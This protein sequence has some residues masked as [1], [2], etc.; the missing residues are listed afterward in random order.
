MHSELAAEVRIMQQHQENQTRLLVQTITNLESVGQAAGQMDLRLQGELQHLQQ[1][2]ARH[3]DTLRQLQQL[4]TET[5]KKTAL[6]EQLL[7]LL[8]HEHYPINE[9]L[10]EFISGFRKEFKVSDRLE[11]RIARN[12]LMFL[13]SL[14]HLGQYHKA[15]HHYLSAGLNAYKLVNTLVS[16]R[17]GEWKQVNSFLDFASGYGRLTRFMTLQLPAS[18][19]WVSDIKPNAVEWQKEIFGVQGFPS[20]YEPETLE[21][22]RKFDLIYVGSLFSHLPEDLFHRW[23]RRLYEWLSDTG[24]LIFTVHDIS[25]WQGPN[26]PEFIFHAQSEDTRFHA[27]DDH[28]ADDEAYGVSYTAESFVASAIERLPGSPAYRRFPRGLALHQDVYTI[29][30]NNLLPEGEIVFTTFP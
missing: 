12:D 20:S 6:A 14:L 13:Y 27:I 26:P 11:L 10:L 22:G 15:Y 4:T 7:F 23:L 9:A 21:P 8:M 30:K 29:S 16:A 1:R 24:M 19:I 2:T 3:E 5:S 18:A 17:N 25:L 28:I